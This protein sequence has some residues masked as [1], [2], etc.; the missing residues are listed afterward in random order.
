MQDAPGLSVLGGIDLAPKQEFADSVA[1][2]G[3]VDSEVLSAAD[4]IAQL[5]L[6]GLRDADQAK[7][8]GAQQTGQP[9]RITLVDFDV[10]GGVL[11]DVAGRADHDVETSL[12]SSSDQ[13]IASRPRLVHGS[14]RRLEGG[15]P[16]HHFVR[17]ACNPLRGDF[18]S[19]LVQHHCHRLLGVNVDF[20]PSHTLHGRR[21]LI[22][23]CGHRPKVPPSTDTS[24]RQT[25]REA[26]VY[27]LSQLAAPPIWSV[28]RS[29]R[30]DRDCRTGRTRRA[31]ASDQPDP[32]L[33]H[34]WSTSLA[35]ATRA[36]GRD[37]G[38]PVALR[39]IEVPRRII[40]EVTV[41]LYVPPA[42]RLYGELHT[43]HVWLQLLQRQGLISTRHCQ[44]PP[45]M[46]AN[47][48]SSVGRSA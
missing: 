37:R 15:Q 44:L 17:S 23:R 36:E 39:H 25:M 24:P 18:S 43:S 6:L 38:L 3:Q 45:R 8:A 12:T 22:H 31:P 27:G 48:S 42:K 1:N 28:R 13:S 20:H 16:L 7:L 46:D 5:L 9:D 14:E 29:C 21:L 33:D 10:V 4:Q 40:G 2:P 34:S 26:P 35:I 11:Q 32:Q 47:S 19:R 30:R 41:V